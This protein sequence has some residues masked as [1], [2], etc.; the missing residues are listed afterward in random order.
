MPHRITCFAIITHKKHPVQVMS[1]SLCHP[2]PKK[3]RPPRRP[4]SAT[5]AQE[6]AASGKLSL[7]DHFGDQGRP[8]PVI[9]RYHP[10]DVCVSSYGMQAPHPRTP[11]PLF[12]PVL[13]DS[14]LRYD[15]ASTGG[16]GTLPKCLSSKAD[17]TCNLVTAI[18]TLVLGVID[19]P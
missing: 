9:P 4:V 14:V 8:N 3:A 13:R 18:V 11:N 15:C 7:A 12:R 6:V 10:A 19:T 16:T 2:H 1:V 17:I 5:P